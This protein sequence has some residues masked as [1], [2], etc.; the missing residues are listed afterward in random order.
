[1]FVSLPALNMYGFEINENDLST[2]K[3]IIR[4]EMTFL[5]YV[6]DTSAKTK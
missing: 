4:A 1:V 2:H 5:M 6:L 3:D